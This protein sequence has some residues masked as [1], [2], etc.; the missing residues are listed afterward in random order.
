MGD[1]THILYEAVQYFL[2]FGPT[3]MLPIILF[4][5]GLI[6]RTPP[7]AALKSA[8]LVGIGFV[9]V[10][11]IFSILTENIAGAARAMV[12]RI[13]VDL[14]IVDL[15]WP[16]LAAIT[17]GGPIA[18]FVIPLVLLLNLALISIGWTKTLDVDVWNYWH[19]ALAGTLVYY[20]TGNFLLGLVAAAIAAVVIIKIA[21]WSAPMVAK[22]F[23]LEG[24]SLPTLSSATF[25]PV[26]LFFNWVIDH[27]P[28]LRNITIKPDTIQRRMGVFGEPMMVG[29]ILGVLLGVAAGY[30]V[31]DTLTL[32]INLGAVMFILPKMVA[33]LMEGLLPLSNSIK[34]WLSSRFPDRPDLY[35]GLDIAVAIGE[36]AV[37]ATGLL[38]VP[39][40]LILA[41]LVPGNGVLPLGDL[42][43][44][45]VFASMIVLA[46]RANVFRALLISIPILIGNL[47]VATA[48]APVITAM[49]TG[50]QF[51]LGGASLVSGFLDGGNP[52]RFWLVQIFSGHWAALVLIPAIA[53]LVWFTYKTTRAEVYASGTDETITH[54]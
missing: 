16:P 30:D 47:L 49:A 24:I 31:Q 33:I 54:D 41:F 12:G 9:G 44:L 48:I 19:F 26:G 39:I 5:V 17:W 52:F 32:G 18:P 50:V 37:I 36:S 45:A 8:L 35:I 20:A 29:T 34:A 21:D 43:N 4:L 11:A 14:S 40:S 1:L 7:G 22:T 27:I 46:C 51:D 53:L 15:G 6:F 2:G 42:A 13:G 3:V 38:L 28:G 23:G 25:F 10:Y